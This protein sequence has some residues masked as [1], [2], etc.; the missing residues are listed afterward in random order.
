MQYLLFGNSSDSIPAYHNTGDQVP[1]DD[2]PAV[3]SHITALNTCRVLD[4]IEHHI[5]S[6]HL[7]HLH[8]DKQTKHNYTV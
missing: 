7:P 5:T 8:T 6:L 1:R 3:T 2:Q 4:K